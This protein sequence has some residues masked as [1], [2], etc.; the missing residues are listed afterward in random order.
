MILNMISTAAF[1][2]SG[3]TY[4]NLMID[5]QATNEKLV[6]RA[7]RIVMTAVGCGEEEAALLC[8]K[9]GR[10][11]FQTHMRVKRKRRSDRFFQDLCV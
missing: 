4:G 10:S 9:S 1:V 2:L 6:D 5:V 11:Y 7:R 8:E 3:K